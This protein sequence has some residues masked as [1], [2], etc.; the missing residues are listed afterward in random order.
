MTQE[1]DLEVSKSELKRRHKA[2]QSFVS[3]LV[4][5]P[6]SQI[7]RLGLPEDI[8]EEIRS[9][10]KMT[11]SAR[12]RQIGFVSKKMDRELDY[13]VIKQ[14]NQTFDAFK[15]P[16]AAANSHFH[17]LES[18]RE[19]LV[20]GDTSLIDQLVDQFGADRQQLRRMIRDVI[21]QKESDQAPT[22]SRQLF[23]YLRKISESE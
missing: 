3:D 13:D 19:S 22:A 21:K 10:R 11:K 7:V 15:H 18:W 6:E 2:L 14:A 23:Q 5:A 8:L 9:A 1:K 16:A 20:N 12:N 4:E 17:Q